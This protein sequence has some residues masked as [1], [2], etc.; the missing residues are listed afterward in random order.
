MDEEIPFDVN[1]IGNREDF[2][3]LYMC[4]KKKCK[5]S[6]I[7]KISILFFGGGDRLHQIPSIKFKTR[8]IVKALILFMLGNL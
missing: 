8:T 7:A 6:L 5:L 3:F 1:V 2:N 4:V